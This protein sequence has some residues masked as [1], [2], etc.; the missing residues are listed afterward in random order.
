L[1]TNL[2][3]SYVNGGITVGVFVYWLMSG[4]PL[5]M[6][7]W[8][9]YI[10]FVTLL[11]LWYWHQETKRLDKEIKRC[12]SELIG[13]GQEISERKAYFDNLRAELEQKKN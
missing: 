1:R 6:Y 12:E 9:G 2:A 5:A 10:V 3:R 11:G 13:L 7:L 8:V 4:N